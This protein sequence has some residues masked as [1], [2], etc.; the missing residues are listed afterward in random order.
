MAGCEILPQLFIL[1]Q[2]SSED[3]LSAINQTAMEEMKGLTL[4]KS[5]AYLEVT[6]G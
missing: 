3:Q 1:I 6:S 5:T 4:E 2:A